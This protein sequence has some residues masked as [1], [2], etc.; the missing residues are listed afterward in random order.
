MYEY[1]SSRYVCTSIQCTGG[2]T[3]NVRADINIEFDTVRV[4][5]IFLMYLTTVYRKLYGFNG[6]VFH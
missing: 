6:E 3:E 4:Q 2:Y 1:G 5:Y